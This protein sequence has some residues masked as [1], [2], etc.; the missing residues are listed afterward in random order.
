[1]GPPARAARA[2]PSGCL[3]LAV[4]LEKGRPLC[5]TRFHK[6]FAVLM[7]KRGALEDVLYKMRS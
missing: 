1:M 7:A 2:R 6:I 4:F 3:G 5:Y